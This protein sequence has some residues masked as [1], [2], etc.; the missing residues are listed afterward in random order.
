MS[1]KTF[2]TLSLSFA[3]LLCFFLF[4]P[5]AGFS[6]DA[7][8]EEQG[9]FSGTIIG[10]CFQDENQNGKNDAGEPG[11]AGITLSLK[12]INILLMQ[13]EIGTVQ[14]VADGRFEFA[15][16]RRGFYILEALQSDAAKCTTKNPAFIVSWPAKQ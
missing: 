10:T 4:F 13:K 3:L 5:A 2:P 9:L 8:I 16:L 15:D 6:A 7:V 14:T 12:K 11:V 1:N